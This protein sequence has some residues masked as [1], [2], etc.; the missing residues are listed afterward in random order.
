MIT[1][2][3]IWTLR[4]ATLAALAC[5]MV[6]IP[7]TILALLDLRKMQ[8]TRRSQHVLEFCIFMQACLGAAMGYAFVVSVYTLLP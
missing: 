8:W 1:T 7:L 2:I 6:A 5:F 4:I 3:L